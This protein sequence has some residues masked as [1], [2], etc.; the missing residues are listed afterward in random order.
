MM[1]V[2]HTPVQ[3]Y[4]VGNNGDIVVV[5]RED[6]STVPPL[7]PL[8]KLRGVTLLLEKL[9]AQ[10]VRKV[11]VVDTSVSK[12][13]QGV[14]AVCKSLGMEC[15]LGHPNRKEGLAPQHQAAKDLG[16]ELY[17]LRGGRVSIHYY[18][19]KRYVESQGG[20][21]LPWGL[22]CIESVLA[23]AKEAST[24]HWDYC[25]GTVVLS[26]GSGT[27]TAGVLLGLPKQP[28]VVYAI[29]SG[30]TNSK[31]QRNI[32]RLLTEAGASLDLM[33]PLQLVPAIMPYS[34]KCEIP[35]PF[36]MHP[37]YDLKAWFWMQDHIAVLPKPVLFWNI[38]S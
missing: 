24:M 2:D 23:V 27:M 30:L 7:P 34:T 18:Q 28:H 5:K 11:G 12:A 32:A 8:A 17:P 35:A 38:G 6:L 14:A 20:T 31:Q 10:G 13:G 33:D 3:Y 29:S 22:V 9:K 21:M 36:P 16:A 19:T 4:P 15:V 1:I 26:C 37:N 25:E